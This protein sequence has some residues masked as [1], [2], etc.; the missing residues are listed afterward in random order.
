MRKSERKANTID[1]ISMRQGR[2]VDLY[3]TLDDLKF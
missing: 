3:I 2:F 1:A